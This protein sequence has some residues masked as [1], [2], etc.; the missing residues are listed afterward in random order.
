MRVARTL[1]T[2]RGSSRSPSSRDADA[3]AA[4]VRAPTSRC[5]SGAARRRV[6]PRRE[7]VLDAARAAGAEAVHPGY[8]FLS[9]NA[10]FARAVRRRRA[11]LG[12]P[13]AGGDRA[14]GRQGARPRR[15]ARGRRADPARARGRA[16]SRTSR[17]FGAEHGFPVVIKAVAGGGGKGMRVVRAAD[18]LDG[19]AGGRAARGA[20]G[21]RRRPR[22]RRALPRARRA[23]S[24]CRCSP[25]AHGNVRPP[26]RAR[27]LAAAPPPEGRRGVA[28]RRS[29]TPRC[30][31]GWARRR[32]RSRARRATSAPAR[33]SSSPTATT[34]DFFFLE[35]NTRLQVEHP[36]TEAV[37]R[38]R[39]GR[40]AAA[41]RRRRA[42]RA[43]PGGG[44]ASTATR[45]RRGSTPRTRRTASCPSAGRSSPTASPPA[46]GPRRLRHRAPA[47]RSA[48]HYDPLLAKVIAH[49]PDRATALG[50]LDR[51]LG[52]CAML[53]VTTNA[54][55]TRALLAAT[56]VRAGEH[57]H[58]A[59]RARL[60][61]LVAPPPD[62]LL[63]AAA[64]AACAGATRPADRARRRGGGAF[65]GHGEV[66]VRDG[67]SHAA[68]A[69]GR[70]GARARRRRRAGGVDARRDLA[71]ATRSPPTATPSGSAAP[72]TRWRRAPSVR[73]RAERR[74]GRARSRRRCPARCCSSASPRATGRR[75]R[76]PARARVDE[77]GA[78]D[79]RAA[80]GVVDGPGLTR[81]ATAW[82]C[83]EPLVAVAAATARRLQR[84]TRAGALRATATHDA[85]VADLHE[86]LARVRAGGGE[87]AP[88]AP[89][90]ARQAA[91]ARAR[92]APARPRLA[93]PRAVAAR[94]RGPLRRR[95]ARRGDR[96]RRRRRRAAASASSSPTTRRSRAAPTT[97]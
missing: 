26:R 34:G 8:G 43:S 21:V 13:A 40:A 73:A 87:K 61:E 47:A 38:P 55:F 93:V 60:A 22:A 82:R 65:D 79:H 77:D 64:L 54:A 23:T 36:V 84:S 78:R 3:G 28:R 2:A 94:R 66:A 4:H 20:G 86:R 59:A 39:P 12:R 57:G 51:A 14:D 58:G 96:H 45:S 95:R 97:R 19:R 74:R 71:R 7:R 89:R 33:S 29:S 6:L 17:A 27:V 68:S 18:E 32:S 70:R 1:R 67:A 81:R 37:Y 46:R 10:A 16:T 5:G 91:A 53:G 25:T 35:M 56:D 48:R 11:D 85:L 75:G 69:R 72:A 24:R 44:R 63:P 15:R 90:R 88:R 52:E 80:R 92:R 42:A 9:E 31:R 83:G 41:G 76:R 62:D 50:R 30:A 49:G